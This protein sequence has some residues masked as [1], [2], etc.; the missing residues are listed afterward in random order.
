MNDIYYSEGFRSYL[1][2]TYL[3]TAAGIVLSALTSFIS[4][5]LLPRMLMALG[6]AY[7]ILMWVAVFAEMGVAMYFSARLAKMSTST[8]WTCYLLYS[9]LTGFTFSTLFYAYSLSSIAM[10][11]VYA[12][13]LFIS[14]AF[15][16]GSTSVDL[17]RYSA[18]FSAGLITLIVASLLNGLLFHSSALNMIVCYAGIILFL[19]II[20]HDIQKL[21]VFYT[22]GG[23]YGEDMLNRLTVYGAFTLYLDFVNI[24]LRILE[25]LGNRDRRRN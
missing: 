18:V 10:A 20:V 24:F 25:L 8:A 3:Y 19:F 4:A 11:F 15:I 5:M 14:M 22:Q 16:A 13:V 17:S 7:S 23:Y 6:Q 12:A 9:V 1:Q 2:K 21:H